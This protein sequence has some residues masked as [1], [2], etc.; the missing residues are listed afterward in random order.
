MLYVSLPVVPMTA[1]ETPTRYTQSVH[2]AGARLLISSSRF[3][4][5]G[6]SDVY[7]KKKVMCFS[8]PPCLREKVTATYHT[9][10]VSSQ[11]RALHR[12]PRAA[13]LFVPTVHGPNTSGLSCTEMNSSRLTR[14]D[15]TSGNVRKTRVFFVSWP[16]V[17]TLAMHAA[18]AVFRQLHEP[19]KIRI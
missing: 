10:A 5:S 18:V 17:K 11:Q 16:F 8:F 3:T 4:K 12:P 19:L 2:A 7:V 1:R 6:D 9:N 15:V 13:W 14:T